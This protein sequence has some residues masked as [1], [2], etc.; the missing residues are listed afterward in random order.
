MA[1]FC[2]PLKFSVG[3]GKKHQCSLEVSS[4]DLGKQWSKCCDNVLTKY[5]RMD[6]LVQQYVSHF[7]PMLEVYG[8]YL[9]HVTDCSDWGFRCIP[10]HISLIAEILPRNRHVCLLHN[11]YLFIKHRQDSTLHN[12]GT[13]LWKKNEDNEL[14]E[15]QR[16][17]N[18]TN[19][20][21][22]ASLVRRVLDW[23]IQFVDTLFKQL[24]TTGNTELSLIYTLCASPLHL[25]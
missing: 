5:S 14:V 7:Q 12:Y 2:R 22:C 24:G 20:G 11:S 6:K 16:L 1:L 15:V 4:S 8:S 25:H 17:N 10:Q 21:L 13:S 23:M 19:W 3:S 18:V 9:G